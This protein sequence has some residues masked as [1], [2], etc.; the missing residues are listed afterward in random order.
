MNK[1]EKKDFKHDTDL[2]HIY[3]PEYTKT[4]KI[5]KKKKKL[6]AKE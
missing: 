6:Y 5:K 3:D 2:D 1:N 4:M